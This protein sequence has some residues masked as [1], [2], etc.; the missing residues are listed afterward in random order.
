[1][2]VP[3]IEHGVDLVEIERIGT[4]IDRHGTHF[5]NRVF[6]EREIAFADSAP[7]RRLER[8]AA[9][10]AA[11]EAA[12]KAIGTGWRSGSAWHDV[13]VVKLA[14]GSPTLRISGRAREF[15][16]K[17][18][19]SEWRVSLSHTARYAIASVVALGS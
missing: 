12:L 2:N 18:G 1:M 4:V 13:E 8:L 16:E 11:K 14:D 19:I 15:A 9:R 3:R 5:L 6:T 7:K 10:F 17:R